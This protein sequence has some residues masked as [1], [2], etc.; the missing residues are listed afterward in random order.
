MLQT[1]PVD[2]IT[3]VTI[4]SPKGQRPAWMRPETEV[5]LYQGRDRVAEEAIA[6]ADR[7]TGRST[8][9]R[10]TGGATAAQPVSSA[11]VS[12]LDLVDVTPDD[13]AVTL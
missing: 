3:A 10:R 4:A 9:Q 7:A 1:S 6:S 5:S 13:L 8:K 11:L 2:R 12:G